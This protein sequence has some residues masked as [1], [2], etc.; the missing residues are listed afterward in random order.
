MST[1]NINDEAVKKFKRDVVG[2]CP[3]L[4]TLK[5]QRK[6]AKKKIRKKQ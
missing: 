3:S 1:Q 4:V 6:K 2:A 5:E